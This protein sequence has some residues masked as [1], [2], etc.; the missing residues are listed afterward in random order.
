MFPSRILFPISYET[1]SVT[2]QKQKNIERNNQCLKGSVKQN[3]LTVDSQN[4]Q[5]ALQSLSLQKT[6]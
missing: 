3:S 1:V 4:M 5:D 6:S 2:L